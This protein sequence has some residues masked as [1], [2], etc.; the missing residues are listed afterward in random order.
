MAAQPRPWFRL[1]SISRPAPAPEPAPAPPPVQPRP[2]LARPSTLFRPVPQPQQTQESIPPPLPPPAAAPQRSQSPRPTAPVVSAQPPSPRPTAPPSPPLAATPAPPRAAATNGVASVP[3]S[4]IPRAAS[5]PTSPMPRVASVP[6][7]PVPRTASVPMSPIPR[8]TAGPT[9]SMQNSPTRISPPR[10][11]IPVTRPIPAPT[12]SPPKP[13]V[14]APTFSVPNSPAKTVP[15]TSPTRVL[16]T[17]NSVTTSPTR[18]VPL[19]TS[20]TTTTNV[21]A[22]TMDR[23]FSPKPSPKPIK[24]VADKTPPRESSRLLQANNPPPSPLTLPPS[25]IKHDEPKIPLEAEPKTV[26]QVQKT[27]NEK[28]WTWHNSSSDKKKET[29]TKEAETKEKEKSIHRKKLH[30]D[31]EEGGGVINITIAGENRG[32]FMEVIHSPKKHSGHSHGPHYLHKK[33]GTTTTDD[34]E[35][36]HSYGNTSSSDQEGSS[37]N[38]K[39]HNHHNAK[40]KNSLPMTAFMNSNVQGVNNSILFNS[41]CTHHDPGLHMTLSRKTPG[42]GFHM[43]DHSHGH[44]GLAGNVKKTESIAIDTN[45]KALL[46]QVALVDVLDGWKDGIL[47]IGTFGFDPLKPENEEIDQFTLENGD[48]ELEYDNEIYEDDDEEEEEEYVGNEE[49]NPLIFTTFEHNFE[50]TSSG[51]LICGEIDDAITEMDQARNRKRTT[52]AELFHA[53]SDIMKKKQD[54]H[55]LDKNPND[56]KAANLR[57]KNDRSFAK[58]FG[59]ESRPLKKLN[60]LMRKM[61]KRKIHPELDGGKASKS[62]AQS[63]TTILELLT[64]KPSE[65]VG[66]SALLENIPAVMPSH[67][68]S[69]PS[70]EEPSQPLPN[71]AQSCPATRR[72]SRHCPATAHPRGAQSVAAQPRSVLP[73]HEETIQSLPSHCPTTISHAQPR[74]AQ[75]RSIQSYIK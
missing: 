75:P 59:E 29:A 16:Q 44:D 73:S 56:K 54:S 8:A 37:K 61:L 6:T 43:K 55:E 33:G 15:T 41:S 63:K 67:E 7:S 19:A 53:D 38:D 5:V 32:A 65:I 48:T 40:S 68:E 34:S 31:S 74:V 35:K 2:P 1:A 20:N 47:T 12:P 42:G 52:L 9:A 23:T 26:M 45:T 21:P 58:K 57:N 28:P 70:H 39:H 69:L 51:N 46:E 14:V 30:S 71:H 18:A 3:T 72:P 64:T 24:S 22:A 13:R 11:V 62:E 10:T 17:S 4:P 60:K 36:W 49:E 25:Q 27:I 50:Y 66:S